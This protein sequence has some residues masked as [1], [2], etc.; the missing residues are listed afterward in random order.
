MRV[1]IDLGTTYCAISYVNPATGKAEVIKN[2]EGNPITPSVLYFDD[3]GTILHGD[4]A[5]VYVEEGSEKTANYFQY[6]MGDPSYSIE[7]NG[8]EYSAA[9][10]FC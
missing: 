8:K 4:D 6:Y 3:D 2:K 1:G 5:K 10:S 9:E 7:R